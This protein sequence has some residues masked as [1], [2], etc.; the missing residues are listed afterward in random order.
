MP[1]EIQYRIK[2]IGV[3]MIGKGRVTGKEIC[4]T[5][6]EIY[7]SELFSR[8]KY[9]IWNLTDIKDLDFP[10]NDFDRMVQLDSKASQT[11]PNIVIAV[12]GEQDLTFG[13]SRMWETYLEF[14]ETGFETKTFRK[15]E[16]A[17]AWISNKTKEI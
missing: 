2:G 10:R 14:E 11:N 17:D 5:L 9:Q 15:R 13:I 1:I 4:D 7:S 6:N 16:D 12:V 3:E 8:Q